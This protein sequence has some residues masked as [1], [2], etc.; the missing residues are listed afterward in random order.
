VSEQTP[1]AEGQQEQ[2]PPPAPPQPAPPQPAPP[3]APPPEESPPHPPTEV[4]NL[5]EQ[6]ASEV[7]DRVGEM[8]GYRLEEQ[9][10]EG[11]MAIVYRAYDERLG[12]RVALKVLAP[13]LATDTGF[14]QRFI[15]ESRAA[16]AV[17]HPNIIPIYEA[18]DIGGA[19]FIAMRYVQGGDVGSL[20]EHEGPLPAARAW[21]II[22][23]VAAALD[24]AHAHDLIHRDVKPANM[25]LDAATG[26]ARASRGS[27]ASRA[28]HVYL[29]DFGISKQP[30]TSSLTLTGQ[31]VGTLDY[32]A[33]E[34]IAG[35]FVDGRADLYSLG[36]AT[37]ELLSGVPPFRRAHGLAL[38]NA[39]LSDRPPLLTSRRGDLP[40][41]VDRVLLRAMAKA[42]DERYATCTD[43]V[44][45]LGR[46]LGLIAGEPEAAEFSGAGAGGR[47][48]GEGERSPWSPNPFAGALPEAGPGPQPGAGPGPGPGAGPQAGRGSA[49]GVAAGG[50]AA[51]WP[52]QGPAAPPPP[53]APGPSQQRGSAWPEQPPR[54]SPP[55]TGAPSPYTGAPS[56]YTGAP[57]PYTGAPSPYAGTQQTWQPQEPP[58][59]S[60]S[61]LAGVLAGVAAI[62]LVAAVAV[63]VVIL[64]GGGNTT[65]TPG[66]TSPPSPKAEAVAV[67]RLLTSGAS[68]SQTLSVATTNVGEC[69]NVSSSIQQIQ[70]VRDQ[71]QTEYSRAQHLSTGALQNGAQVK[72]Y[73]VKSLSESLA[74]D[75]AYLSWANQ[76]ATNCQPGG[77][78]S[79][80][81]AADHRAVKDKT[82]FV[83]LWNPI[84]AK[85]SLP[86]TSVSS[87]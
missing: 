42:P 77:P 13:A 30:L 25:L 3:P 60:R 85:Y 22:S 27:P 63:T 56:P 37:F 51:A 10:G 28:Q 84:A 71:R 24:A 32:I 41:S 49:H 45:D 46:A 87:I 21:S 67:S 58:R 81:L 11:G 4:S 40:A 5:N 16:A 43:F 62:V 73:L 83:A 80:A 9:I 69:K 66:P 29:S 78:S 44:T 39:H 23:Q 19:L 31:F 61:L 8:A 72:F 47:P 14:R 53:A 35:D 7:A 50:G 79:A 82:K 26:A 75:N 6:E 70:R 34:Q 1:P 64:R 17:D 52:G 57:S 59:R 2:P 15:R 20:L 18:G 86:P 33:P 68:S 12:R 76:Q 55:Y 38:I 54:V 48:G 74:A 65:P 36:C